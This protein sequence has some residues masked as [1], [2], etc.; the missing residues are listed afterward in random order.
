M[1]TEQ[2]DLKN[3]ERHR[4]Y[5]QSPNGRE[6]S[7]RYEQSPKGRERRR[8]YYYSTTGQNSVHGAHLVIDGVEHLVVGR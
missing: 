1:S 6:R 8:R 2:I 5:N 7:R 3:R 4:R